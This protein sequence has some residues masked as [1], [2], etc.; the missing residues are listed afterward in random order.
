MKQ[1]TEA[2]GYLHENAKIL[3]ADL[4]KWRLI[5]VQEV[6]VRGSVGYMEIRL[7]PAGR[8]IARLAR[9]MR[10]VAEKARRD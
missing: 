3:R 10:E 6:T 7:T 4:E 2:S 5:D 8:E 1:F 9:Q